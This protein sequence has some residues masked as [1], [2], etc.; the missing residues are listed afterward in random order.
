MFEFYKSVFSILSKDEI[1][2]FELGLVNRFY[3]FVKYYHKLKSNN[4]IIIDT[5]NLFDIYYNLNLRKK[6][7][8][9]TIIYL[10]G[11]W[12]NKKGHCKLTKLID[13]L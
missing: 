7:K 1:K 10:N 4:K 9:W 12:F 6:I 11:Y 2:D 5:L 8:F 3:E 13:K